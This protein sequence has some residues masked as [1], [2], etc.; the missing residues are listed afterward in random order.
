MNRT[1]GPPGPPPGLDTT[2]AH[3]ARVYDYWLG[4]EDNFPGDRRAARAAIRDFPG[5]V[6]GV[7]EQRAFLGRAVGYLAGPSGIRQFLDIGTGLPSANNTHEVAQAVTP[8][9][10]VVYVDNDP[11]V[12]AHAQALLA[13]GPDGVTAY[14][15][16][17]LRDTG[18]ILRRA[19]RILDFS[20][21]VAILLIGILQLIPDEDEP[22][23]LVRQLVDAVPPGSWQVIAHPASEKFR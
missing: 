1:P 4:G 17:D 22:Y 8:E 2:V 9:A 19:A 18:A 23:A 13:S 16:A 11:L 7:R 21:P 20:R 10:R 3:M 14:L 5:I 6:E 12:L 15:D